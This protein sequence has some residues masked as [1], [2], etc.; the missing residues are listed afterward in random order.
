VYRRIPLQSSVQDAVHGQEAA[1]DPL[2]LDQEL[3]LTHTVTAQNLNP[4]S[5]SAHPYSR[6]HAKRLR[7]KVKNNLSGGDVHPLAAALAESLGQTDEGNKK[8]RV[9]S[10]AE[11]EQE[12]QMEE[13]KKREAGKIGQGRGRTLGEK[14]R[15]EIM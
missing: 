10:A 12:R 1:D 7:R 6:S 13:E 5:L 11:K 9:R 15:R 14:K 4:S 3:R 2:R 8:A